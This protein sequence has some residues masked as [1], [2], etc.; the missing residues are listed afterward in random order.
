ML[1]LLCPSV[2][3]DGNTSSSCRRRAPG[4][5]EQA[6]GISA[7]ERAHASLRSGG[8]VGSIRT[9]ALPRS[10]TDLHVEGLFAAGPMDSA[11]STARGR[12]RRGRA[13]GAQHV[14][15]APEARAAF[16]RARSGESNS[17]ADHRVR[18]G[19]S[20]RCRPATGA[21]SAGGSGSAPAARAPRSARALAVAHVARE[22]VARCVRSTAA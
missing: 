14:G 16:S 22:A 18:P 8:S 5:G 10:C 15:A 20:R 1:R 6:R 12:P 4:R 7:D 21:T 13:L 2:S 3:K 9:V 11:R 19:S 17:P